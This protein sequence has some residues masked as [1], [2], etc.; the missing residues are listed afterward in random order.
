MRLCV[1]VTLVTGLVPVL[2]LSFQRI[3]EDQIFLGY[4]EGG[5][6]DHGDED[7]EWNPLTEAFDAKAEHVLEHYHVPGIAVSVV[8]KGQTYAKVRISPDSLLT[9][10]LP[11]QPITPIS[12]P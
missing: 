10:Y 5:F 6:G 7:S 8:R 9:I 12:Y 3:A 4:S 11:T 1:C 2:A